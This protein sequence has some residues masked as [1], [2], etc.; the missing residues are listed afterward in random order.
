MLAY[1]LCFAA[2]DEE[3]V[4]ALSKTTT[5]TAEEIRADY[6]ACDSGVTLRM[7][8][9]ASYAFTEQDLRLNAIYKQARAKAKKEGFEK[10]LLASQRGWL[11][12]LE[13][14][15]QLQA[16]AYNGQG[17]G[18]GIWYLSCKASLTRDRANALAEIAKEN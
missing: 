14:N 8:I 2:P 1:Q 6:D 5:L 13:T 18:W 3:V 17:T 9:C 15:C 4:K 11:T 7:K 10:S 16:D 12:Y